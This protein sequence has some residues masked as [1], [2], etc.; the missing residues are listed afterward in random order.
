MNIFT[1][2]LLFISLIIFSSTKS[3]NAPVTLNYNI[4][5][6]QLTELE[7]VKT[8][9]R[10]VFPNDPDI[11]ISLKSKKSGTKQFN[12]LTNGLY[13]ISDAIEGHLVYLEYGDSISITLTEIPNLSRRM[14]NNEY[15][16]YFNN[17]VAKGK[18]AWHYTFFDELYKRTN[19]L[20]PKKKYEIAKQIIEYKSKCDLAL[21][22]GK[23]LLDSLY[24]IKLISTNFK[25]VAEQELNAIYVSRMCG[26]LSLVSKEK[27]SDIYFE[28]LN[29]MEFN[30]SS[31]AVKCNDYIQAGALYTY[32]IHNDFN[33]KKPYSNLA[34]EMKS[35]LSNYTGIIKDKLLSWQ[36][37]DYIGQ[38]FPAF[39]SC[40]KVFFVECKNKS[41]KNA[42][43]KK[44]ESYIAPIQ[45][46]NSIKLQDLLLKSQ[47]IDIDNNTKSLAFLFQDSMPILIDCW[48]TWCIPCRD[49][50][51]FM[52]KIASKYTKQMNTIY[53]SFDT[54]EVKWRTYIKKN[55]LIEGQYLIQNDFGSIFSKYFNIQ[56]IPRYILL[57]KDGLKVLNSDLPLPALTEQFEAELGKHIRM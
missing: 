13:K 36:I 57:S 9:L 38:N 14:A 6:N 37:Q 15:F 50:M 26:P 53:L 25:L 47:I 55:N 22:I 7:I 21:F 28:K 16:K 30:D 54:E 18:Y 24:R 40:Y 44:V 46:A 31:Y 20:Y 4:S 49:Q 48:A 5:T 19:I 11:S 56:T 45:L 52:H 41:F 39:D 1:G 42:T 2:I 29:N 12:I 23:N 8:G 27:V 10:V 51:P 32:Y 35:I 33:T 34:M 17:L 43:I 3:Q